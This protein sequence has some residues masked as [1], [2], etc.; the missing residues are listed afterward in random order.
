MLLGMWDKESR[1]GRFLF[2]V[3]TGGRRVG[4]IMAV[5]RF[6][7]LIA[8]TSAIVFGKVFASMIKLRI[9]RWDFPG[10]MKWTLNN[11]RNIWWRDWTDRR[12][13]DNVTKQA[14][15]V[16]VQPHK[17]RNVSSNQQ[18]GEKGKF[19]SRASP[20]TMTTL[21]HW[22][23]SSKTEFG[24]PASR[25]EREYVSVVLTFLKQPQETNALLDHLWLTGSGGAEDESCHEEEKLRGMFMP[26]LCFQMWQSDASLHFLWNSVVKEQGRGQGCV[27]D[28]SFFTEPLLFL[29]FME[30]LKF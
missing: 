14:E 5:Q 7:V 24:L 1:I 15:I 20:G 8:G 26:S 21:T 16:V 11:F 10:L 22:F 17:P 6:Q 28:K 3:I 30:I 13:K 29:W 25:T 4:W 19:S 27:Q 18:L 12:A 2:V 9:S 23:H